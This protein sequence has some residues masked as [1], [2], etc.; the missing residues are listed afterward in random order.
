MTN[1]TVTVLG[2]GSNGDGVA[3][4]DDG[5]AVFIRNAARGD[6]LEIKLLEERS[7]SAGAEIIRILTPSP[8]RIEPDCSY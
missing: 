7:R 5:R 1:Q 8:Y 2:Y 4:L 3:R 6:V